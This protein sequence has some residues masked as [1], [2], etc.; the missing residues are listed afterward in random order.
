[1][2]GGALKLLAAR[3]E[4][5]ARTLLRAHLAGVRGEA[6]VEWLTS[7]QQWAIRECIDAGLRLDTAYGAVLT[8]GELGSMSPYLPSGAYL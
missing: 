2:R 8:A 5:A 3:D 1:V 4:D 7:H 6:T